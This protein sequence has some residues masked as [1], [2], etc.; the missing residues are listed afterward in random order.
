MNNE[1]SMREF[2]KEKVY[3]DVIM[4]YMFIKSMEDRF[5][6]EYLDRMYRI[7]TSRVRGVYKEIGE[8]EREKIEEKIRM[9]I[10]AG[11]IDLNKEVVR[12]HREALKRENMIEKNTINNKKKR[13]EH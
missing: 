12:W 11:E 2:L 8:K 10:E 9:Q 7:N 5:D 3:Y 4:K 6:D 13:E 1:Q